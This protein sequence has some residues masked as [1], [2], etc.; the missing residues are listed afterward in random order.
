MSL[1]KP[2]SIFCLAFL[3]IS[4]FYRIV[5]SAEELTAVQVLNLVKAQE[6]WEDEDAY[7]TFLMVNKKEKQVVRNGRRLRKNYSKDG[8]LF[9]KT[10]F[11]FIYPK[12]YYG[13]GFLDWY[14]KNINN[15]HSIWMYLP[16]L[17]KTRRTI[18]QEDE[19]F[20]KDI[21][22]GIDLTP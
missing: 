12:Q 5:V 7:F 10:V 8:D 3:I 15:P 13:I 6:N 14:N 19:R 2:L 22:W 21:F 11:I 1:S 18:Y 4:G 17:R 9:R 16:R 20:L